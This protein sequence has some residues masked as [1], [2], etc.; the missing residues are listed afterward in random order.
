MFQKQ[1]YVPHVEEESSVEVS[2]AVGTVTAI[3]DLPT[4]HANRIDVILETATND[5][6]V[7]L[8]LFGAA[9]QAQVDVVL[10]TV[11]AGDTA[12]FSH[13]AFIGQTCSLILEN[14]DGAGTAAPLT[15]TTWIGARA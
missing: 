7:T 13:T 15:Y 8:R 2:L 5:C 9:Q 4:I 10:G 11:V 6:R 14:T 1:T 12:S 3:S